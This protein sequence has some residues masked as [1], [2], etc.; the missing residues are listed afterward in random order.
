MLEEVLDNWAKHPE[1][2]LIVPRSE[3]EDAW[4]KA[5]AN[6]ITTNS[7]MAGTTVQFGERTIL[8]SVGDF[9]G[10]TPKTTVP[11]PTVCPQQPPEK[12]DEKLLA[13]ADAAMDEH[14]K[15][16]GLKAAVQEGLR[17]REL[18]K[19][20]EAALKRAQHVA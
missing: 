11:E 20:A 2:G 8:Q 4:H 9:F 16:E 19:R 10:L 1:T 15:L 13:E 17:R 3:F 5:T 6:R 18:K 12:E 7:S 14:A